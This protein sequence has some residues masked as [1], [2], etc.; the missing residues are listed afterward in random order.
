MSLHTPT[1][2]IV[3]YDITDSRRGVRVHR[4]MK[5]QGVPLQY[6]VFTVEASAAQMRQVML[7]LEALIDPSQDDVRAYRWADHAESHQLGA[8]LL[9][10]G[11]LISGRPER[12]AVRRMARATA[13]G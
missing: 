1:R 8:D 13:D 5:S 10:E 3:T 7:A 12:R 2:W 6:S 11:V 9:P 4:Y